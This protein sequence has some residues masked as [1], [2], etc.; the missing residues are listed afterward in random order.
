[1]NKE[2]EEEEEE[3]ESEG[4][5]SS[6]AFEEVADV[7]AEVDAEVDVGVDAEVDAEPEAEAEAQASAEV[8]SGRAGAAD[9]EVEE[10]EDAENGAEPAVVDVTTGSVFTAATG[11]AGDE[12][13]EAAEPVSATGAALSAEGGA[14]LCARRSF[15][16]PGTLLTGDGAGDKAEPLA[17]TSGGLETGRGWFLIDRMGADLRRRLL[18][19]EVLELGFVGVKPACAALH[20]LQNHL[21]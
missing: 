6:L 3:E 12:M 16:S 19:P 1:M 4:Y 15:E 5:L 8:E 20:L 14:E 21:G 11:N 10:V 2:E 7:D 18:D 17:D 9:V 13:D